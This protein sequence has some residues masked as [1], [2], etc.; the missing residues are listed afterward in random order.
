M[1]W[2]EVKLLFRNII[3]NNKNGLPIKDG[4]ICYNDCR[5][6]YYDSN[7]RLHRN[8]GPAVNYILACKEWHQ[9]GQRH[10]IDGPAIELASGSK[11]WCQNDKLHRL[12]G[13]A[14]EYYDGHKEWWF[15]DEKI[16]CSSQEKFE[17][18][19]KLAMFW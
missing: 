7:N 15:H 17:E 10:R 5:I 1:F 4:Y 16:D 13:P 19:I 9:H 3:L 12:D 6:A 8:D 11:F 14:V 18:Q 2:N